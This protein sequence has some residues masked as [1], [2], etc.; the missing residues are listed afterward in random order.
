VSSLFRDRA[1]RWW[2]MA[3]PTGLEPATSDVT[4]RKSTLKKSAK[5]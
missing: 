5:V 1:G 2:L 4:E 3:E